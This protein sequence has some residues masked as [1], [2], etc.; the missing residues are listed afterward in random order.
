MFGGA[1]K[2][3]GHAR[4]VVRDFGGVLAV[5]HPNDGW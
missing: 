2:S 4:F 1:P 5:S 3:R